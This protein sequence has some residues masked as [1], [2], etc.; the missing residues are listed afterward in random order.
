MK[1]L[2][3]G[4]PGSLSPWHI[5]LIPLPLCWP[6]VKSQASSSILRNKD[7]V[8]FRPAVNQLHLYRF[9]LFLC[10]RDYEMTAWG[11]SCRILTTSAYKLGNND[12]KFQLF[13]IKQW[14]P[15]SQ[16]PHL[17]LYRTILQAKVPPSSGVWLGLLAQGHHSVGLT[18]SIPYLQEGLETLTC[19][20]RHPLPTS[21]MYF[22]PN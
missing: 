3:W 10:K 8:F 15:G 11:D 1:K 4:L 7:R 21:C 12:T 5:P 6:R 14:M 16:A 20:P 13:L 17:S 2:T 9:N 18:V 19:I 22:S